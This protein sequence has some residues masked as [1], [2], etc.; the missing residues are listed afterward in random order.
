M[1]NRIENFAELEGALNNLKML[2]QEVTSTFS[3]SSRV[4]DEQKEGWYSQTSRSESEKMMDYAEEAKKIAKNVNEVSEAIE[5]F[6][7]AT[8]TADE[9]R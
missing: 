8:R 3:E 4:Y 2:S 5:K 1:E 6:K 7:T 9:Q